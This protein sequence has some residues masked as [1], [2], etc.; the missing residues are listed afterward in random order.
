MTRRGWVLGAAA[1]VTVVVF[2]VV[3]WVTGFLA[4]GVS[5]CGGGGFG[6]AYGPVQAQVGIVVA[7]LTLLPFVLMILGPRRRAV[8][9]LGG[10]VA[11]LVGAT[12]AMLVI[13][14]GPNGCPRGETRA[15]GGPESFNAGSATCSGDPGALPGR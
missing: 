12:L 7:G 1:V 8:R 14:L 11:V 10:A 3:V 6:P 2:A 13:G 15:I 4:C 9:V 5:G